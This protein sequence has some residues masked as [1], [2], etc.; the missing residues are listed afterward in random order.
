MT[1]QQQFDAMFSGVI[2]QDYQL[3]KL[4]CPLATEMSRLVGEAVKTFGASA[5]SEDIHVLEL[6]GG[7]GITTLSVLSADD[8]VKVLSVDN[9]P[10]MQQQAKTNLQSWQEQGRVT[11]SSDDA[12]TALQN[13]ASDSIDMLAS[14]YTLHNFE[15]SYR[16]Q[17]I[18]EIYRVLKKDGQF[19]NGDR[20]GLDDISA[21]TVKIQQEVAGYFKVL[22]EH[23]R[24]DVLEHWII[25]LFSDESENHV[26]RESVSLQ[27]LADAGFTDIQLSNRMEVN[28]LVTARK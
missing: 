2:G 16:E 9:E 11:F 23:Q 25:H 10:T 21:H 22:T 28:A 19:I 24:L 15:H 27:Q 1:S 26:M 18:N 4:I 5:T 14:A 20:Y 17:V 7:T 6:G 12:L 8:R 3:L 13:I